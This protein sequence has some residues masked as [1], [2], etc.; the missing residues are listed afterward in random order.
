MISVLVVSYDSGATLGRCLASVGGGERSGVE[1]VVADNGSSDGSVAELGARFPAVRWLELGEN[2]GFGTAVNRAAE[3]ARGNRLLLLNPDAWLERDA[4]ERLDAALD[5]RPRAALA[6][7]RLLYPEGRLQ[8]SWSPPVS[9][10]GEAM[11]LLRNRFEGSAANHGALVRVA[12]DLLGL[13]WFTAACMLLRR[14]AFEA[15]E[16]FD[17]RFFLYFEDAD[18][19]LRL[20]RAGWRFARAPAAVAVHQREDVEGGRS[21]IEYRRSQILYYAKHRPGWE[22]R[23][24]AGRLGRKYGS[25][26]REE[27]AAIRALLREDG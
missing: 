9:V 21:E 23:R 15:V 18:L 13:G 12:H 14:E 3:I 20:A 6:S 8:F 17:E 26:E 5:Q 10:V 24:L 4:L 1:V 19:C 11:R 7:P 16:G 22:R 2:L 27:G 25:D